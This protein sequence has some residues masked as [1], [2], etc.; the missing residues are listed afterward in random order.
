MRPLLRRWVG[1][2]SYRDHKPF[3]LGTVVAESE[4]GAVLALQDLWTKI[5]P[6]P[7]PSAITAVPGFLILQPEEA[8]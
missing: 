7:C 5:S 2:C 1:H 4:M 6:H 8:T 3:Y